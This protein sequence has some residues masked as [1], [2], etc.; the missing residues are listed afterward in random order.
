[1]EEELCKLKEER[2]ASKGLFKQRTEKL[3]KRVEL[4]NSRYESLDKR[5]VLEIEGYKS[6]I[7][8]LRQRLKDVEKQLYKVCV[9]LY[10]VI[11]HMNK[12]CNSCCTIYSLLNI[13]QKF[14]PMYVIRP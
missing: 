9:C 7:K 12:N 2:D 6:D 3:T 11:I 10:E 14:A 1:M 13:M 4:M 5:R 8:L